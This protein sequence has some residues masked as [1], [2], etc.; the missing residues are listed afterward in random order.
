MLGHFY[1]VVQSPANQYISGQ[2]TLWVSQE[3]I[4]AFLLSLH[5]DMRADKEHCT[6]ADDLSQEYGLRPA[7]Y[8]GW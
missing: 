4:T 3:N 6:K 2:H 5:D 1:T 8:A 7:F